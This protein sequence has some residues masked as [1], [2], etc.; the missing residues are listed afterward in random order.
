MAASQGIPARSVYKNESVVRGH[1]ICKTSWT[2]V[3]GEELPIE[4]EE[5]NQQ[6]EHVVAVMKNGAVV[7]HVTHSISILS[8]F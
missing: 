2:P 7:G 6:D 8:F 4:G 1:H 3:I 5:D